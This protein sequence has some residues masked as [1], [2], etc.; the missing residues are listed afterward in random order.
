[1]RKSKFYNNKNMET[2]IK[3]KVGTLLLITFSTNFD[4]YVKLPS[5]EYY[6]D[7]LYKKFYFIFLKFASFGLDMYICLDG[8]EVMYKLMNYFKKNFYDKGNKT[9]SFF[10][11][12]KFYLFSAYKVIGYI[13]IF[14]IVN[15]F[16]RYYIYMHNDGT[17]FS[18]YSNNIINNKKSVFQI[19]N[20]ILCL[21][22]I[23]I[24][25]SFS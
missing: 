9:I 5:K 4:V 21:Y 10:G 15:Y 12:I 6:N 16:N 18:Y 20:P 22:F 23:F 11:I 14:F 25:I 24:I 7:F 1:M 13:I 17:L 19:F 2:I 8:F 3:L